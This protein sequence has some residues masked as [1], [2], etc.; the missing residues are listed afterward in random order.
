[1]TI[2]PATLIEIRAADGAQ[3]YRT[4]DGDTIWLTG[5]NCAERV[6][7]GMRGTLEY[8]TT[9]SEGLWWFR[10]SKDDQAVQQT[11]A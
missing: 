10:P 6:K 5:W 11:E 7:V 8:R 3:H 4:D 2:K 9:P 1:M